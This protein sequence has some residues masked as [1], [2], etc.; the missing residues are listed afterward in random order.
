[1][2]VLFILRTMMYISSEKNVVLSTKRCREKYPVAK[3]TIVP[4]ASIG[5]RFKRHDRV[6]CQFEG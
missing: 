4:F 6:F 1:M 2:K 3:D 5:T